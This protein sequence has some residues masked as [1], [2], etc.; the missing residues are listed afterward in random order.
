MKYRSVLLLTLL[1]GYALGQSKPDCI[2]IKNAAAAALEKGALRDALVKLRALKVCDPSLNTFVD[3]KIIE[4][5][6][7][8][9]TQKERAEEAQ[10]RAEDASE[11]ER[12][13]KEDA[14]TAQRKAEASAVSERKAREEAERQ[15]TIAEGRLKTMVS[16]KLASTGLAVQSETDPEWHLSLLLGLEAMG[17]S[18]SSEADHVIRNAMDHLPALIKKF[19]CGV[20]VSDMIL[21]PDGKHFVAINDKLTQVWQVK[22]GRA[23]FKMPGN[24]GKSALFTADG[25][26]LILASEDYKAFI[27][28]LPEGKLIDSLVHKQKEVELL[29]VSEDQRFLA[30]LDHDIENGFMQGAGEV[31]IWDLHSRKIIHRF[32]PGNTLGSSHGKGCFTRVAD[33]LVFL[34]ANLEAWEIDAGKTKAAETFAGYLT[35][36]GKYILRLLQE[37]KGFTL[38]RFSDDKL[39]L[40]G[41]KEVRD[42][43]TS[44]GGRYLIISNQQYFQ[45]WD[46]ADRR[47][48]YEWI[49]SSSMSADDVVFSDNERYFSFTNST[50]VWNT[51]SGKEI[52]K[53]FWSEATKTV[54][55]GSD[56]A[57]STVPIH[58][59]EWSD[60]AYCV[61]F[62]PMG[63]TLYTKTRS[64][65]LH[66]WQI[67]P[68]GAI[69]IAT[70]PMAVTDLYSAADN[71]QYISDYQGVYKWDKSGRLDTLRHI[72]RFVYALAVN[73][74]AGLLA[75]GGNSEVITPE[76][77]GVRTINLANRDTGFIPLM[78]TVSTI[79]L[80]QA[81]KLALVGTATTM[82]N[83]EERGLWI[84]D[85]ES[86]AKKRIDSSELT[87]YKAFFWK[88]RNKVLFAGGFNIQLKDLE[89]DTVIFNELYSNTKAMSVDKDFKR[90]ALGTKER[91]S[92]YTMDKDDK[93]SSP[94]TR[95]FS[96][97]IVSTDFSASGEYLLIGLQLKD[98]YKGALVI[99]N[100]KD[101]SIALQITTAKLD[102]AVFNRA[103]NDLII[104]AEGQHIKVYEWKEAALLKKAAPMV[105]R[106]LTKEEW[107]AYVGNEFPFHMKK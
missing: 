1:T 59:L 31:M 80:D 85:L 27:I 23:V 14:K 78:A 47:M 11:A 29:A 100:L 103:N 22:T 26:K 91:V 24:A 44:K 68:G 34:A 52:V 83:N 16:R 15:T 7:S 48:L 40:K 70:T 50:S 99:W 90:I 28:K 2:R 72:R 8:I 75:F 66:L 73:E 42:F 43:K 58:E 94:V 56:G 98:Y 96:G 71:T 107:D 95:H 35:N 79:D 76:K 57:Q 9:R 77:I 19:P 53:T 17:L 49:G 93:P 67:T 45:V 3:N 37:N 33:K 82:M 84:I 30:T 18:Y 92:V 101:N 46:V 38:H 36:D 25:S 106:P 60:P 86:K 54:Q 61:G 69:A 13:A 21:S 74:K 105:L 5:Y 65:D 62:S 63:D 97:D 51:S 64:G 10:R 4:V 6:D 55:V 32:S 12:K 39:L 20:P 87:Y 41:D 102:K 89:K 88:S 104:A 81:G